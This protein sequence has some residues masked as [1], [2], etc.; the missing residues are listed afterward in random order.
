MH[1]SYKRLVVFLWSFCSVVRYSALKLKKNSKNLNKSVMMSDL[2]F[3]IVFW[4]NNGQI[5]NKDLKACIHF[6][7]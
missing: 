6:R 5:M 3:L 1:L 4:S 2:E 7:I